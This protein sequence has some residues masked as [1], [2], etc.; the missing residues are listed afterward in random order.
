VTSDSTS[1]PLPR[2]DVHLTAGE[3]EQAM[4]ADA[5]AGL[6]ASPKTLPPKW[7]YDDRGSAL[8]DD[9]TRL[10]EYYPTRAEREILATYGVVIAKASGATSLVEL[11]A[12]TCDKTRVL[13]DAMQAA[14][15]LEQYIGFDISEATL[16]DALA[17]LASQYRDTEVL[18]V[19]G[20]FEHHIDR[21]PSGG[22][23]L[24]AFLGGTIGNLLPHERAR[25]FAS[26]A[27]MLQPGDGLLLGADIVKDP[28]RIVAAYD[29]AAGVT[30]DFNRNVL[31]ALNHRLDADFDH[32][33]FEHVA[34][35]DTV[36]EWIEMR[37]R[38]IAAQQVTIGGLG[39]TV[40]FAAGEE[41]RT[42]ISAKFRREGLEAE[43]VAAGFEPFDWWTDRAGDFALTMAFL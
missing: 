15:T 14:G 22:P 29:D 33:A 8:F 6:T 43:L 19:V 13:L 27:G 36:N 23:R 32:D 30:S 3:A 2:V 25:F 18:G 42:E 37:L 10:P 7:L 9:I 39:L 5:L 35:W 17:S 11:G 24:V 34:L 21:L 16:R 1:A 12:G 4:R 38:A 28:E 40:D 41:L 20:D 26:V 31:L